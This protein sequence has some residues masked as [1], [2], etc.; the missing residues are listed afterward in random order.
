MCL[1]GPR[2]SLSNSLDI[3][4]GVVTRKRHCAGSS[5]LTH[6][7]SRNDLPARGCYKRG[8]ARESKDARAAPLQL[9]T[10]RVIDEQTV[11]RSLRELYYDPV[12]DRSRTTRVRRGS[13]RSGLLLE[14]IKR[15]WYRYCRK[16]LIAVSPPPRVSM[17]KMPIRA[18]RFDR[19]FLP[20]RR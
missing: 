16:L 17:A 15:G 3:H 5:A 2:F 10:T 11:E 12:I 4:L 9:A 14:R 20:P 6:L 18:A 13:I 19:L 8:I 7:Q 1:G